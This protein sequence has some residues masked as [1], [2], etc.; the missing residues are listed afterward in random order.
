MVFTMDHHAPHPPKGV[1]FD[2]G[3]VLLDFDYGLA[4]RKFLPRAKVTLGELNAV[5]NGSPLLLAYEKGE[6]NT[7]T[8]F[9]NVKQ[10]TGFEGSREEFETIF[11]DIFTEVLPMTACLRRLAAAGVPTYALSNTNEMAIR[12]VRR[13][14]S[15]YR[16][17][18]DHI[19]SY[20]HGAMKP[21]PRLYELIERRSGLEGPDLFFLDDRAEN[22]AAARERNWQGIVHRD[23]D[24][25]I[26]AMRRAGLPLGE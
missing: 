11:G 16:E 3:K 17:F 15:F 25:S 26:E 9:E 20:E 18:D 7:Q 12:H 19:L 10:R 24:E 6:M 5:I 14:Y 1:V 8:F 23:P 2:L 21:D 13:E 4:V 22:V